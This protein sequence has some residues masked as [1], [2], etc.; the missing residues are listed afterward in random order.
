ML[1]RFVA[2]V[3]LTVVASAPAAELDELRQ[4]LA[5]P[6][7]EKDTT[8]RQV[9][10]YCERR[11]PRMPEVSSAKEWTRIAAD[12]R[13]RTLHDVVLRG[14]AAEWAKLP[15]KVEWFDAID[16]GPEYRIRKLRYEAVPGLWIP[17]LLYEPKQLA[18]KVPV[19]L[20][21]NG[22]DSKGKAAEY[23]QVRCINLAKRGMLALNVEWM[24]MGQLQGED[25]NHYCMNQLDLCG[26]SG[27]A[28]HY[29][30][31]KRAI[32]ILLQH[33]HADSARVGVSGLSG[34]GWQTIFISG[35][36][37]RVTLANP[38]AG[39]SSFR[40]RAHVLPDLGDSEQT[41]S[42]L[43]TVVD[44]AHLT[45]M[46]APHPLL[47]TN[48]DRDRC[49]F[50]AGNAQPLLLEAAR[51]IY[52]L[53]D[54]GDK[55]WAHVNH[56]PGSH[57]FDRDNREA[58]YRLIGA[59]WYAGQ[60]FSAVEIECAS[61]VKTA[62]ELSVP[63]PE[64][65]GGFNTLAKR[66]VEGWGSSIP[67]AR[68]IR[69]ASADREKLAEVVHSR[70]IE[71]EDVATRPLPGG[72]GLVF[73]VGEWSVPAVEIGPAD[74]ARTVVVLCDGGRSA[75]ASHIA[76]LTSAGARVVAVD[77]FYFGEAAVS[78][79]N[80]LYA[81]L[82]SA[83]GERPLGLQTDQVRA[84]CRHLRA[85]R[86]QTPIEVHA[87]GRRTGLIAL[88]AAALEPEAIAG[89]EIHGGLTSLRQVVDENMQVKDEPE[90]FCFGLLK[91]FDIPRIE[92]LVAPQPV[93][94]VDL[95]SEPQRAR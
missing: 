94:K 13:E 76:G 14:E 33:E 39:Y 49:C 24:R 20:A 38:V 54:A 87:I 51:P 28:V 26:T 77:P 25:F 43:A 10:D 32:D 18:G 5:R 30:A 63:L 22:H 19:M 95:P 50:T 17:A 55:L 16:G 29:L 4:L 40:T 23:K 6:L 73:D 88:V 93:R 8:F 85:E 70:R 35:L 7:L 44:Y 36:D 82:I 9:Q 52:R 1:A 74:A 45:A 91:E 12:L 59:H 41:P 48:N 42:D 61:E 27:I 89:V 31:Q 64:G 71:V 75:A 53:Y 3:A 2:A 15:T 78:Q 62:E 47:L 56:V 90:L 67:D 58:L 83:V 86:P 72:R 66:L 81:L 57:N 80:F 21:V 60:E 65:N 46:R 34:G 84:V 79:K 11:V 92:G 37:A 69:D 68:S